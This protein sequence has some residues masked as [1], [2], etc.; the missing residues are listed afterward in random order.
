[1]K[2]S[3]VIAIAMILVLMACNP[4]PGYEELESGIYRKLIGFADCAPELREAEF[5][6]MDVSFHSLNSKDSIYKF[7]LHHGRLN[8]QHSPFGLQTAPVGLKLQQVLDSMKCGDHI[9]VILPFEEIDRSYI[10]AYADTPQY[11]LGEDIEM[12]LN[13]KRTF[14]KKEYLSYLMQCAQHQEMEETDAIELYLMNQTEFPYARYGKC[15]KQEI[16][17][18][19][20]D[21]IRVG[22]Y[23]TIA[24]TTHL[25]DGTA[26]DTLTTLQFDFGRPGQLIGG[27]QYGLSLM[28]EGEHARIFLPSSLAFGEN[29]SSTGIVPRNTPIYFDVQVRNVD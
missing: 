15:F 10:S 19:T 20:G 11:H 1:M 17:P 21:S 4:H 12:E 5:F 6:V 24:Y 7:E 25:L 3:S 26:L 22:N 8:D 18:A 27:F 2:F 14:S 29:G 9:S 28:K 23:I 13:L 16:S